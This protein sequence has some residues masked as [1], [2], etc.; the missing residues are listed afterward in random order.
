MLAIFLMTK[1]GNKGF[2]LHYHELIIKN[3]IPKLDATWRT[4]IRTAIIEKLSIQPETFGVPLRHSLKE[5][6]KL[7]VGDYRIIFTI[8]DMSILILIIGHRSVVYKEL[9]SRIN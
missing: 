8:T 4:R 3:D 7:R 2:V 5:N 1:H 9:L 6:W